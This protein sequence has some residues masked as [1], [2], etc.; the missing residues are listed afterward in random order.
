MPVPITI[1]RHR[2]I[3]NTSSNVS[4]SNQNSGR[5]SEF[6][7]LPYINSDEIRETIAQNLLGIQNMIDFGNYDE[8]K[9]GNH[10]NEKYNINC[11][12]L[13][14]RILEKGQWV[15]VKDTVEKWL[16]AQIIEVSDDKKRVKI[17]YNKWG[18]RWDEWIET[19]SPRIMPFRYHTRQ[20][21]LLD[22]NS[23]FPNKKPD[24][25]ITLLSF[26][27]INKECSS[28][29]QSIQR[30]NTDLNLNNNNNNIKEDDSS[31]NHLLKNLGV[32]GFVSIFNELEGINK[33]I[34]ILS[35]SL[36]NKHNNNFDKENQK[37][38]Y[39][40]LKRLIPI[41]DR[42]GRIYIDLSAFFEHAIRSNYME[43]I[44]KNLFNDKQNINEELKY[45][46][47]EEKIRVSKEILDKN[48]ERENM[49]GTLNFVPPMNKFDAKLINYIPII[50]TPLMI[51]REDIRINPFF[52]Q[53]NPNNN[54]NFLRNIK[55]ENFH[56]EYKNIVMNKIKE[57][58][59]IEIDEN[60]KSNNILGIKTKRENIELKDNDLKSEDPKNKKKK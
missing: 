10:I 16:E 59:N 28:Q 34:S 60:N 11:F 52:N 1:S 30:N 48:S 7:R 31:L 35:L 27:D 25:G 38:F 18:N 32:N 33:V 29:S 23:P 53:F 24:A 45:F 40:D 20:T 2:I 13:N 46:S 3:N 39:Y 58:I 36:L 21:S 26:E 8:F 5:N 19:N 51:G 56:F 47:F 6:A 43:L 4:L 12:D 17:H 9:E 14:K 44:S 55:T 57:K 37:K 54:N 41:L 22:Y 49:S 42:T 15:D 50:D